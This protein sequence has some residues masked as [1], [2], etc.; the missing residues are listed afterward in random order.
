MI[1]VWSR[2]AI[3]ESTHMKKLLGN[4]RANEQLTLA[5]IQELTTLM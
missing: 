1:L 2:K 4:G 3:A 5:K